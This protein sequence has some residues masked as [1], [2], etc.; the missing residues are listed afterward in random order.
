[1]PENFRSAKITE[2]TWKNLYFLKALTGEKFFEIIERLVAEELKKVK[3]E[4]EKNPENI[5][6]PLPGAHS[7]KSHQTGAAP[8]II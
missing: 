2:R 3:A 7:A 5:K 1:M 4:E 8:P 6:K